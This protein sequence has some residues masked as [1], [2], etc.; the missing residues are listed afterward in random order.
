MTDDNT[1]ETQSTRRNVLVGVAGLGA[2]GLFGAGRASAQSTPEG[3]VGTSSNPYLRAY[4]DRKVFTN[5]TT[6]PSTPADGTQWYR[7]DL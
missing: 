7:S 1:D 5:R 6:D 4:I 2:A 3:E